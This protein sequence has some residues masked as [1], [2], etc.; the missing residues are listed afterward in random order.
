MAYGSKDDIQ[1]YVRDMFR[2]LWR[3]EGGFI[4]QWYAD[5]VGAGHTQEAIDT[6]CQEFIK[7]GKEL[8]A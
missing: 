1:R 5:P 3:P 6:M 8:Y 2:Y 4:P 7:V